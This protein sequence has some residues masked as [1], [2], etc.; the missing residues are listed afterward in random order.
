MSRLGAPERSDKRPIKVIIKTKEDQQ[1]V[2]NSLR[3]LKGTEDEFGKISVTEDYTQTERKQIEEWVKK[4][5]EQSANDE[6]YIYKVRGTPKNGI[7]L[8]RVVRK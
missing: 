1:K 4:A 3:K 7:H 2:M 6:K 8:M 5:K